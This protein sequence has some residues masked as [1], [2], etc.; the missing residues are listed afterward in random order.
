MALI[1]QR[2]TFEAPTA[3]TA[4]RLVYS[5]GLDG[6]A[7]TP[8]LADG[9]RDT[10]EASWVS[11]LPAPSSGTIKT[12]IQ[13]G[14]RMIFHEFFDAS[15][16]PAIAVRNAINVPDTVGTG[17]AGP[18]EVQLVV[19]RMTASARGPISTGRI[20]YGPLQGQIVARP[21]IASLNAI[22]Q[23]AK[24]LHNNFL[25]TGYTPVVIAKA[26]TILAAGKP[27]LQYKADALF[28]TQRRR[29][30]KTALA[31]SAVIVTP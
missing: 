20:Y 29:G 3:D 7:L 17:T 5:W 26:G 8:A 18:T 4:D 11:T 2:T 30:Y 25:F 9:L 13:I 14:Y 15:G 19:S 1:I 24:L 22:T 10:V 6:P 23:H 31:N 21:P 12:W 27:I 16:G 28:D